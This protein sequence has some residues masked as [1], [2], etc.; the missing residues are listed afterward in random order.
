MRK[1]IFVISTVLLISHTSYAST[2]SYSDPAGQGTQD[3]EGN[4]ALT[5]NVVS[6]VIV[7][8]LGVF[9]ASGSGDIIGSIQVVIYDTSLK[10]LVTPVVTFSGSYTPEA[11]GFDVFQ[12]IAPVTL[13]PGSY[14]V[15]AVGFGAAN[16]NG[17]L[18]TGSTTGPVMNNDT[19]SLM[20]TGAAYDSS[21]TLDDPTLC[22]TCQL[23]PSQSSQFDA[24]TFEIATTLP[25]ESPVPE[26]ASI[27]LLGTGIVTL[28]GRRFR[29]RHQR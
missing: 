6:P 17:N 19:G 18:N 12:P 13:A 29:R 27:M 20:F 3:W 2:I 15:D 7:T 9:N 25:A 28:I 1:I 23:P 14:E 10:T 4:L 5:F 26:P 21:T 22:F 11:L 8:D 16:P 24:G